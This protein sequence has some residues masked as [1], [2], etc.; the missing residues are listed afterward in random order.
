MVGR[1][2]VLEAMEAEIPIRAA[3]VAEGAERDDRLRDIFRLAATRVRHCSRS[4]APS[5][6]GLPVAR[7]TRASRCNCR[8]S[9]M[10][11]QMTC[12]PPRGIPIAS[13]FS[14]PLIRSPTRAIWEQ[15][16]DLRLHSARM[17]Y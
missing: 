4:R 14:S 10:P 13:H 6:T 2:A 17:G 11:T 9:T 16:F 5:W 8:R 12:S 3:Y 15:S 1:N 7:C